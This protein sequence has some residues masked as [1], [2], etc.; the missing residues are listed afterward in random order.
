MINIELRHLATMASL[1][2]FSPLERGEVRAADFATDQGKIVHNFCVTYGSMTGGS[3]KWPSLAVLKSRFKTAGFDFPDPE[4]GDTVEALTHEVLAQVARRQIMT[5]ANDL[6][7]IA[8][9]PNFVEELPEQAAVLSGVVDRQQ[10]SK[11]VDFRDGLLHLLEQIEDGPLVQSGVPWPWP[12]LQDATQ[13]QQKK[14]LYWIVG[15]PKNKKTYTALYIAAMNALVNKA[16]GV[17]FTPEM[18]ADVFTLRIAALAAR[19]RYTE[20][21]RGTLSPEERGR[22]LELAQ[23]IGVFDQPEDGV[24]TFRLGGT[25]LYI[26]ESARRSLSWASA[27][28]AMLKPRWALFDSAYL[29]EPSGGRQYSKENERVAAV[30]REMKALTM[31]EGITTIATHQLNRNASKELAG[32]EDVAFSDAV[33]QDADLVLSVTS[34]IMEGGRV[35]T[36]VRCLAAREIDLDGFLINSRVCEDFT[37]IG[38]I[39]NMSVVKKLMG[40]AAKD[41]AQSKAKEMLNRARKKAAE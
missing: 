33:G 27:Q 11:R 37:E 17:I 20:L 5:V 6:I 12:I 18:P 10:K 39:P 8:A 34:G 14:E 13:G 29:H 28:I 22:L 16:P 25:Q 19:T 36:A 21:K 31:D 32:L 3:A 41:R 23:D 35:A 40:A 9:M 2:D 7:R 24:A 4:P 30:S 15:R 1:G 38:E 26:L